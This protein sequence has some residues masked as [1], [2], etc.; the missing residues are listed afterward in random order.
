MQHKETITEVTKNQNADTLISIPMYT[1]KKHRCLTSTCLHDTLSVIY[2]EISIHQE[3]IDQYMD[4]TKVKLS[5]SIPLMGGGRWL[6]ECE[7]SSINA[8]C[9]PSTHPSIADVIGS[10]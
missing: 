8:E 4:I 1:T 9:I 7:N 3:I 10:R 6:T 5:Q 2:E